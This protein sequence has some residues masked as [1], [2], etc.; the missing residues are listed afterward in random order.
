MGS[1]A[2]AALER[3]GIRCVRCPGTLGTKGL[4]EVEHDLSGRTLA[5]ECSDSLSRVEVSDVEVTCPA[6]D[7]HHRGSYRFPEVDMLMGINMSRITA[8]QT[9]ER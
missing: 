5:C 7:L 9:P 6:R 1:L 2:D 4:C 8:D 3:W